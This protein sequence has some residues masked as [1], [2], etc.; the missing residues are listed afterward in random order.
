MTFII[1]IDPGTTT[2][3]AVWDTYHN[4]FD[5]I[6]SGSIVQVQGTILTV[7]YSWDIYLRIE[8]ARQR[9]WFARTGRERLQ[10]AGSVKRDC[11]IWQEFCEHH[12]FDYEMTHPVRGGTKL[13]AKPFKAIT[14]WGGRTN[15]N[16]RDA[17][18]LVFQYKPKM[19]KV[20][21]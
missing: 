5:M 9:R 16:A 1:G 20:T 21:P 12:G 2:G 17:A 8:D 19:M 3:I 11:A 15:Q 13:A 4:K 18:M 6:S 14:G 10:G 7:Y